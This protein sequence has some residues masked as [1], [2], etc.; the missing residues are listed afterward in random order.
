METTVK[1]RTP[2]RA[3]A[4]ASVRATAGAAGKGEAARPGGSE[5]GEAP[6]RKPERRPAT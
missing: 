1:V 4:G 5:E 3:A 2:G 6:A